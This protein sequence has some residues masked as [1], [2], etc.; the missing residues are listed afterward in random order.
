MGRYWII[1]V[2]NWRVRQGKFWANIGNV[3]QRR[4]GGRVVDRDRVSHTGVS[5]D[6]ATGREL[7]SIT[8]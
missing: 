3:V 2:K 7:Y 5:C 4:K 8:L 6:S 1:R